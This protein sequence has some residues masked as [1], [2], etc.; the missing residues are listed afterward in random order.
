MQGDEPLI[1]PEVILQTAPPTGGERCRYRHGGASDQRCRRFFNPNVVKV[2]AGPMAMRLIFAG[3]DSL[4]AR[5]LC[6][7]DGGDDLPAGF[8]PIAMSGCMPTGQFLK[9]YAGLS[10]APPNSSNRSNNC[11]PVARLSHQRDPDRRRASTRRDTP[12]DAERMRKCLTVPEIASNFPLLKTAATTAD[13]KNLKQN[14]RD[15]S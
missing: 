12:E 14:Q 13:N 8:P 2:F 5:P 7:E 1:E 11:G 10:M 6:R 9:A 3:A 4:C 15:Y